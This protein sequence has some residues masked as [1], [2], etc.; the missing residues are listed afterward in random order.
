MKNYY[1]ESMTKRTFYIHKIKQRKTK[2]IV[3]A[4]V[5]IAF[6]DMLVKEREKGRKNKEED[7]SSYWMKLMKGED[8][9]N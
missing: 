9:G 8:D 3:T 1:K 2:W 4:S 5:G 6:Y 7:V